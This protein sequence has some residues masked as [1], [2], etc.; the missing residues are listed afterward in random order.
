MRINFQE[1][2][3]EGDMSGSVPAWKALFGLSEA[4]RREKELMDEELVEETELCPGDQV[5]RII[6][7][8]RAEG[9]RGA[10]DKAVE[11]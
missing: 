4:E 2:T 1:R 11:L 3:I 7:R 5:V 9:A 10:P 8:R 6:A